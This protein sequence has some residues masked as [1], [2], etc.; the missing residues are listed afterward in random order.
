LTRCADRIS[1]RWRA[2]GA[3]EAARQRREQSWSFHPLR[4]YTTNQLHF[5]SGRIIGYCRSILTA[6]TKV[7]VKEVLIDLA[8]LS[9]D[10]K[11]DAILRYF[12]AVGAHES[13]WIGA[14]PM[15]ADCYEQ[16]LS[17]SISRASAFGSLMQ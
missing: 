11:I 16:E 8:R 15:P 9:C 17:A 4:P 13:G 1:C 7:I 14:G 2:V 12:N 3:A 6:R 10:F 5:R